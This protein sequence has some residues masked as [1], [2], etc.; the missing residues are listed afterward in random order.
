V[1]VTDT[2]LSTLAAS[3]RRY[4]RRTPERD[5]TRQKLAEHGV[6][7]ADEPDRV[8]KRLGR[9]GADLG[10]AKAIE[11]TPA[12]AT[13]GR[14]LEDT[15]P[16]ESFGADVLGLERLMGRNDLVDVGFLERGH[17]AS[18]SVGRISVSSP[19]AHYGSGFMVSP[20][21]L[22]TNNHVLRDRDEAARGCVEFNFQAGLDGRALR[23][24][25]FA[26]EPDSFFATSKDLDFTFV[27]VAQQDGAGTELSEFG[28]LRLIEEQGKIV[29]GEFLNVIQHPNGEPK[30]L[31]LRE[32][33][34]VDRLENFLHYETDTAPGSSGS[35]VF[36]DQWEVVALHH[37]GVPRKDA[38]GKYLAIDGSRWTSDMGEQRLDWKAN[39]GVRISRVVRALREVPLTGSPDELRAQLFETGPPASVERPPRPSANGSAG[40]SFGGLSAQAETSVWTLPLQVSVTLGSEGATIT[41]SAARATPEEDRELQAALVDVAA[42]EARTYYDEEADS[43]ACA[44]YYAEIEV[45]AGGAA[46]YAALSEL[47]ETTHQPRPAY[48]PSRLVYPWVD[49][50]PDGLLRSL[51]S[52][53]TFTAEELIR[54]DAAVE[55]ARTARLEEF[56][57]RESAVGPRELEAELDTLEATLPF[58]CEHVVPQSWFAKKEPMRGDLHHLFACESGCNSFRGNFPY[59][60]FADDDEATRQECGR[61]EAE[62]FE[63][64]AGKGPATRATLYF[65]MRYPGLVG[66]AERELARDRLAL[67]LAWHGED[68]VSLYERHRNVAIAELQGNRNPL[69]DHPEWA[70]RLDFA[71][72]WA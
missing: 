24:V 18:R 53:K 47:L 69:I 1:I 50:H 15:L 39:E 25:A 52:G 43:V 62:G 29:L 55:A 40:V 16:P 37:S 44:S 5:K 22:L 61:R 49:Q 46:L 45:D 14:S 23:P 21:L 68:P 65:L 59:F 7:Y 48:K 54:A 42:A 57:R 19:E 9:L 51:Y 60:D 6:L 10:L 8:E 27:A 13:S 4:E 31:A 32:N 36:N 64:A 63:P 3:S 2:F 72:A 41:P 38:E 35:P 34:L 67:L 17:L 56:V 26:L 20:R 71:T 33:K 58:N 28:W 30:Q 70:E 11:E 66:D 12:V